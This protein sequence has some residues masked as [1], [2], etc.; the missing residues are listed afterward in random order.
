MH[1]HVGENDPLFK[2]SQGK[3]PRRSSIF[4]KYVEMAELAIVPWMVFFMTTIMFLFVYHE[5]KLLVW[6][7]TIVLGF[8][9]LASICAGLT[10]TNRFLIALSFLC[11]CSVIVSAFVGVWFDGTVLVY[12]YKLR[13]G[14]EYKNVDPYG[15]GLSPDAAVMHFKSGTF[16]DDL[17]TVGFVVD[18]NIYCVA[19]VANQKIDI[20]AINVNEV[21]YWATGINCCEKRS[22]F[23]CGASHNGGAHSAVIADAEGKD[24][25]N[26]A[27]AIDEASSYYGIT[28]PT[29]RQMQLVSF[30]DNTKKALNSEFNRVAWNLMG[31]V[32]LYFLVSVA[33]AVF[34]VE[35][36]PKLQY[37]ILRQNRQSSGKGISY[38][39]YEMTK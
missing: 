18:G 24:L 28:I 12:Y 23:H 1:D 31:L 38:P 14:A 25:E 3:P 5:A 11:F 33:L 16:V 30:V 7:L 20:N 9:A 2:R 26:Y 27:S 4:S 22:N 17:R 13:D 32:F 29:D 39:S 10:F 8:L 6:V 21:I 36:F 15:S 19:P 34:L 35:F 37:S